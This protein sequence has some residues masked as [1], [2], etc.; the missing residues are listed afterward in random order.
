MGDSTLTD[1]SMQGALSDSSSVFST[2]LS[3]QVFGASRFG[4]VSG[5]D[6][7]AI[8]SLTHDALVQFHRQHYHPGNALFVSY[9]DIPLV[10]VIIC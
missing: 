3:R 9:G 1:L 10:G 2:Q 8:P 5:G 6:P 7:L 4:F